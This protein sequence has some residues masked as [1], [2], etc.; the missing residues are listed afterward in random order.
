MAT[1]RRSGQTGQEDA[2]PR[3][4]T[5]DDFQNS[6]AGS[7]NNMKKSVEN[8]VFVK[9]VPPSSNIRRHHLVTL[10]SQVGPIKKCSVIFGGKNTKKEEGENA[11]EGDPTPAAPSSYGFVKYLDP[12]DAVAAVQRYNN[13]VLPVDTIAG[14]GESMGESTTTKIRLKVELASAQ[15][16]GAATKTKQAPSPAAPSSSASHAPVVPNTA[17]NSGCRVIV[18]N[19]SFYATERHLRQA[20]EQELGKALPGKD[21]ADPAIVEIHIP[22]V[23]EAASPGS[24]SANVKIHHR[25][26]A[27]VTF[28]SPEL[29]KRCIQMAT[30]PASAGIWIKKR[31]VSVESS[32]DKT[33]YEKKKQQQSKPSINPP[34]SQQQTQAR[35][36]D[37]LDSDEDDVQSRSSCSSRSSGSSSSDEDEESESENDL[38]SDGGIKDDGSPMHSEKPADVSG[39]SLKEKRT[40]FVRNLA[41]DVVRQDLFLSFKPF[42]RIESIYLNHD[43]KT[44]LFKGTAFITYAT[45]ESASK[46][47]STMTFLN[48]ATTSTTGASESLAPAA[49]TVGVHCKGRPVFGSWAV[50]KETA[51]TLVLQKEETKGVGAPGIAGSKGKD[52]RHLYLLTEGR[53]DNTSGSGGSATAWDDLPASDQEKRQR[54]WSEKNTKLRSPIFSINPCRLSI[55][56]LAKH[57]DEAAL[58]QLISSA[59]QRGL[60][61]TNDD[62]APSK[63]LVT[64]EDQ[65]AHWKAAG[66]MT[67]REILARIEQ[68]AVASTQNAASPTALGTGEEDTSLVPTFDS[69][70]LKKY[71]PS[72]FVVRDFPPVSKESSNEKSSSSGVSRGFAFVEF[73]EHLHALACLREINNNPRYSAQYV[74]GGKHAATLLLHHTKNY[75]SRGVQV[76]RL[77]VEFTVENVVKARQQVEHREKQRENM[78]T[79]RL[80]HQTRRE[81]VQQK[82]QLEKKL[83]KGRGARQRERKRAAQTETG[84]E[85][86]SECKR[87]KTG[88][89]ISVMQPAALGNRSMHIGAAAELAEERMDVIEAKKPRKKKQKSDPEED[90]FAHLV[91]SYKQSFASVALESDRTT[92][93]VGD[94]IHTREETLKRGRW[95]HSNQ[96]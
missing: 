4:S 25:G 63:R 40:L 58:R 84:Q 24:D 47:L 80:D 3:Q 74:A 1:R 36:E 57:V 65:I 95:F 77:I 6:K 30:E 39:V 32:V 69:K 7:N 44:Q 79:Q 70:N 51:Q 89:T 41:F 61:Y 68:V 88:A 34:T 28:S 90:D 56:N 27:F 53:V 92:S 85:A 60:G 29:A 12:S 26:F 76:P 78:I 2:R 11:G 71:I 48:A 62:T 55:R 81:K 10:F 19:L 93:G 94:P 35:N 72:V 46:A 18:R 42:G 14:S 23:A 8:T 33:S 21:F 15:A 59:V 54:A 49:A 16:T 91:E 82:G 87:Q 37:D 43:L 52:K 75:E 5:T 45:H 96:A 50:D 31:R 83:K 9:F 17:K 73:A 20:I 86:N 64:A 66:N 38:K 67:T 13:S 22:T